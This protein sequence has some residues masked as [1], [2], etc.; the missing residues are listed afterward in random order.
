MAYLYPASKYRTASSMA[1]PSMIQEQQIVKDDSK[2]KLESSYKEDTQT[3]LYQPNI[4]KPKVESSFK[5]DRQAK[6]Y[7]SNIIRE[8]K[9]ENS[10]KEDSQDKFYQSNIVRDS[11]LESSYKEDRAKFV[12][13]D[14]TRES[15]GTK[16]IV[17]FRNLG[18]TCFMNSIL[19]CLVR[20]P[21]LRDSILD[22]E[23]SDICSISKLR[24]GFAMAFKNFVQEIISSNN[25]NV[26]SPYEVKSQI[27]NYARQ[28]R[29]YEQQDAAEFLR[30]FLEALN[31]DLNR[32]SEKTSYQEMTGNN[33]EDIKTIADRWW[34][35]SL[36]RDNSIVT[37]I[38]QGQF[39]SVITCKKCGYDSVSCDSFLSINLPS[40]ESYARPTTL[41]RCLESYFKE[42]QLPSSYKCEKCKVKG[43][44]NQKISLFRFPKV[45]VFQLKRFLV[46]G[47]RKERLNTEISFP[48]D[49]DLKSYKHDKSDY[50]PKYSLTGISHHM[51]SLMFGHYIGECR[52]NRRWYC[53]DDSRI[54]SIITPCRSTS[55]Y[56]LFYIA[57]S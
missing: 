43:Y 19:Q 18:N 5:E 36:S 57:S 12:Q 8:S 29:G 15:R 1:R 56:I 39:A 31:I 41:D 10:Y 38:F 11:K 35:Y 25:F 54:T 47:F 32:I 7:Q 26:I 30:H 42:A 6:F 45:L 13:S 44:C 48:E 55:A 34:K 21:V 9:L 33:T 37:D 40:S 17:G 27:G 14:S 2:S 53:F 22:I 50:M 49:L 4:N 52:E 24:G 16:G 46:D 3:K 28:Y 23:R 51:G 20:L